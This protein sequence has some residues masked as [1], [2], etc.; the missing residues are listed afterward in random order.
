[1]AGTKC[2]VRF[3]L[4]WNNARRLFHATHPDWDRNTFSVK[5][6]VSLSS[7]SHASTPLRIEKQQ[8]IRPVPTLSLRI[9]KGKLLLF[10]EAFEVPRIDLVSVIKDDFHFGEHC[11]PHGGMKFTVLSVDADA[12][13]SLRTVMAKVPQKARLFP[14]PVIH[15]HAAPFHGVK[16]FSRV[17]T[18]G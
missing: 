2:V 1:M 10:A 6:R 13:E 16:D 5:P 18:A 9:N 3:V 12:C 7:L 11:K 17:K 8:A 14:S 15:E 4:H